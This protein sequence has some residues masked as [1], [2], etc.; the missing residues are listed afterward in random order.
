MQAADPAILARNLTAARRFVEGVLGGGEPIAFMEVVAENIVVDTGL[1]PTGKIQGRIEY[2]RV[3][4]ETMGAAFG[5]GRLE[6]KD[7]AALVD[8]R[9]LVRFAGFR[10]QRGRAQRRCGDQSAFYFLRVASDAF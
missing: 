5:T 10:G 2:D 8:G 7:L 3:L 1:N 6:I 4:G 9:V